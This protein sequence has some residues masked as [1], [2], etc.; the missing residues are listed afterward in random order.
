MLRPGAHPNF[1]M[2]SISMRSPW[3]SLADHTNLS[4][5]GDNGREHS[6]A[7]QQSDGLARRDVT[8]YA[9]TAIMFHVHLSSVLHEQI[10][11]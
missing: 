6:Q 10:D 1:A 2:L 3:R 5:A 8:Q 7:S 4:R 9:T 11:P